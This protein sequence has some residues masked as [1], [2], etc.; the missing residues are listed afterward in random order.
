MTPLG[1]LMLPSEGALTS[2]SKIKSKVIGNGGTMP[3]ISMGTFQVLLA[4]IRT[5]RVSMS[6]RVV[7]VPTKQAEHTSESEEL[8]PT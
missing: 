3:T 8:R 6:A 1:L 5:L 4:T 7:T 2:G